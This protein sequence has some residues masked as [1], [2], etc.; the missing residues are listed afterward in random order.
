MLSIT[1]Q[2]SKIKTIRKGDPKFMITDGLVVSPRAGFEINQ[3]CPKEYRYIIF[4]CI[5]RGWL[6]PVAHI[7]GKELTMD[8]MR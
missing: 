3:N 2:T 1:T 4:E 8:S 5:E 7:H 6:K